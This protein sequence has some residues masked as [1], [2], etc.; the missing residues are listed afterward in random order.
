[1]KV[2]AYACGSHILKKDRENISLER[3]QYV[4]WTKFLRSNMFETIFVIKQILLP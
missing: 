2:V 1:M 4:I 3:C